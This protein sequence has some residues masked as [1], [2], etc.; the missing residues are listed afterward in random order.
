MLIWLLAY[1]ERNVSRRSAFDSET[2]FHGNRPSHFWTLRI[3]ERMKGKRD[4]E[5]LAILVACG[6]RRHEAAE[7]DAS[8]LQQRE[9]HWAIVDLIGKASP[10]RTIPVPDWVK[11]LVGDWLHATVSRTVGSSGA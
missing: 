6:L 1:A 8:D 4:L 10:I 5:L 2:G 3:P 7:L 11:N 9:D